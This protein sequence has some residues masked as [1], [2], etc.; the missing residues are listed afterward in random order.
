MRILIVSDTHGRHGNLE[1]IIEQ[2]QPFDMMLHLGDVESGDDYIRA[3]VDCEVKIVGGNNDYFLR[4][5][6][7]IEFEVEG[8]KVFMTHGHIYYIYRGLDMLIKEGK[9]RNADVVMYGHLHEP[10][11][12]EHGNMTVLSPGSVTYP[13][14]VGRVPSYII[15][16]VEKGKK[17]EYT[18]CYLEA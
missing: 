11:L 3:L 7:D 4:L 9:K 14:Q 12:E 2:E 16:N 1:K 13:R 6:Y 17:P 15:M 8:T 18:I 5:P 10:Y